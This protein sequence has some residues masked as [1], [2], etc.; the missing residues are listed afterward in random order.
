LEA[1][2]ASLSAW[3]SLITIVGLPA[4][5]AGGVTT[6][7][8]LR[9]ELIAPEIA[10]AFGTGKDVQFSLVNESS[11]LLREPGYTFGLWDLDARVDGADEDPGNLQ[12][13]AASHNYIRPRSALGPWTL[14][15]LSRLPVPAG[16]IV[17]GVLTVQCPTCEVRR[18]YWLCWKKGVGAWYAEIRME[19]E[20]ATVTKLSKILRAGRDYGRVVEQAVP[21]ESRIQI[22]N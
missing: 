17:F 13:P 21:I 4:L 2:N 19:D 14:S 5:L 3:A 7:F 16:H 8:Q 20:P 9:D 6:Y 18:L 10:L 11:V 1:S 12:M 15:S 22:P